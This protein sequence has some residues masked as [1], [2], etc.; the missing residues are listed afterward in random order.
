MPWSWSS[1]PLPSLVFQVA[2]GEHLVSRC[3]HWRSAAHIPCIACRAAVEG[4]G[5]VIAVGSGR[6]RARP[7]HDARAV[8][9]PPSRLRH[10]V[11]VRHAQRCTLARSPRPS[12]LLVL[13]SFR[14]RAATHHHT[15]T[16]K[17][18]TAVGQLPIRPL[19][20]LSTGSP[21]AARRAENRFVLTAYRPSARHGMGYDHSSP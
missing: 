18:P 14:N 16:A 17:A 2:H 4:G 3:W 5:D 21:T 13:G 11:L 15:V 19:G 7:R 10:Y 8:F 20:P 1:E 9:H 6:H 12:L